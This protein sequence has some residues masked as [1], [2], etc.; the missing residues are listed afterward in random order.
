MDQITPPANIRSYTQNSS[1]WLSFSFLP[2]FFQIPARKCTTL[3]LSFTLP[4]AETRKSPAQDTGIGQ[5]T[6]LQLLYARLFRTSFE[7]L[8]FND[9]SS[10][11][12]LAYLPSGLVWPVLRSKH[13]ALYRAHDMPF[14]L[15]LLCH[16]Q[17]VFI[18]NV[19]YG[20]T[21]LTIY[22]PYGIALDLKVRH[23]WR[24]NRVC[25]SPQH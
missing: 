20:L 17:P 22:L 6:S 15:P 4:P 3:T 14:W 5:V 24:R 1:E 23:G 21:R 2:P 7:I 12:T 13:M 9:E 8:C 25:Q 10:G 18:A 19:P 11:P 16:L